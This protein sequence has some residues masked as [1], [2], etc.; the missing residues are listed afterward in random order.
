MKAAGVMRNRNGQAAA[1]KEDTATGRMQ[2]A[3]VG[4]NNKEA[5]RV[6]TANEENRK[7][8]RGTVAHL[9]TKNHVT[10]P[11]LFLSHDGQCVKVNKEYYYWQKYILCFSGQLDCAPS[12]RL[13]R[14]DRRISFLKEAMTTAAAAR[15]RDRRGA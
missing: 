6:E 13:E 11:S 4:S 3:Q 9:F 15:S 14:E 5:K 2:Q 1:T 8:R 10:C 7:A 12:Q